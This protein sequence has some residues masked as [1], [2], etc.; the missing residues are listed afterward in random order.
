MSFKRYLTIG[1]LAGAATVGLYGCNKS[2]PVTPEAPIQT[3]EQRAAEE[4]A[5]VEATYQKDLAA[6]NTALT[7][8][9]KKFTHTVAGPTGIWGL[10]E[11][12]S[13]VPGTKNVVDEV[14]IENGMKYSSLP[15]EVLRF[16]PMTPVWENG[17]QVNC[18]LL[19]EGQTLDLTYL[20]PA[21]E[22]PVRP[23][24]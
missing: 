13:G 5:K 21:L 7:Q 23:G 10:V 9:Q 20:A 6:Y 16:H 15:P 18:N 22:K 24:N 19:Y 8:Q 2:E 14:C 11:Q 12:Y 17:K 4:T 3:T 1:L